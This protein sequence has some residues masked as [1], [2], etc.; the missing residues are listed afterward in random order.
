MRSQGGQNG[1]ILGFVIGIVL[2]SVHVFC[3][4]PNGNNICNHYVHGEHIQVEQTE[5]S[6]K[7]CSG[8][9]NFKVAGCILVAT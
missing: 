2:R 7:E 5:C 8:R 9:L 1:L 6:V 3:Y 4:S